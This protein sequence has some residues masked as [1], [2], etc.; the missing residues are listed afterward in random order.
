MIM[1]LVVSDCGICNKIPGRTFCSSNTAGDYWCVLMKMDPKAQT[2]KC[3]H[4]AIRRTKWSPTQIPGC[5]RQTNF[6]SCCIEGQCYPNWQHLKCMLLGSQTNFWLTPVCSLKKRHGTRND[7]IKKWLY[8][9]LEGRRHWGLS[10]LPSTV[11]GCWVTTA[12][13]LSSL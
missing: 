9:I 11:N 8:A 4:F 7:E 1:T 6:T 3:C 5:I 10:H 2:G 12:R 13:C